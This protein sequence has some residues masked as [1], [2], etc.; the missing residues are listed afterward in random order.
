[1]ILNV[2]LVLRSVLERLN[3]A[4][5]GQF[6]IDLF[7]VVS[8]PIDLK[9]LNSLLFKIAQKFATAYFKYEKGNCN[10]ENFNSAYLGRL[11]GD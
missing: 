2:F 7:S 5:G 4:R 10:Y 8:A 6:Q 3:L 11:S 9:H 1:M